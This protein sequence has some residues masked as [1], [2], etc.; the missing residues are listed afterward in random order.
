[1]EHINFWPIPIVLLGKDI[2]TTKK[3]TEGLLVTRKEAGLEVNVDRPKYKYM[4][5][6]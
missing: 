4:L 3:N 6:C 1:M 5:M 2:N